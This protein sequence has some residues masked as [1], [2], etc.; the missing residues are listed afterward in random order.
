MKY[1]ATHHL[2]ATTNFLC[3]HSRAASRSAA[4]TVASTASMF[5]AIS[6]PVSNNVRHLC[7]STMNAIRRM[8]RVPVVVVEVESNS[9]ERRTRRLAYSAPISVPA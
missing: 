1:T 4:T 6:S 2:A 8:P 7:L 3:E 9:G 5:I